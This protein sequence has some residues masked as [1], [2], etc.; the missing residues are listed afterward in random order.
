MGSKTITRRTILAGATAAAGTLTL[1]ACGVLPEQNSVKVVPKAAGTEPN[2]LKSSGG[3]LS[4]DL[5]A[6]HTSINI[7]GHPVNAM[8]YNGTLP[9]PT[10]MA[11]PGDKITVNFTNKL[12]EITNLHTHGFHVSP[13]GNSDNV[14]LEIKDGET[15]TYE[16]QLAADHPSGT[17]WYH[18]HHH[19]KAADQ[20]FAGLYGAIIIEDANPI[21]T[22]ADRVLVIS[23]IAVA[24]DGEIA[25]ATMMDKMMGREGGQVLVNGH[26][27][28][29]F[30]STA[31]GRERLHIVNACTSR[32][33]VLHID[34]ADVQL[35]GMDSGRYGTP[36]DVK[37]ILIAPGNRADVIITL[38]SLAATLRFDSVAHLDS[39]NAPI[40]EQLLA[41]FMPMAAAG[42]TAQSTTTSSPTTTPSLAPLPKMP[43]PRDIRKSTITTKRNFTLAM[44]AMGNMSNMNGGMGSMDG[45]GGMNHTMAGFTINGEAFDMNKINTTVAMGTIEEWTITNTTTMN[46]PFHLHV[47]P[48]QILKIGNQTI[49]DPQ[50]QDVVNVPA[51]STTVVRVAFENHKG[52][53]VY[54]CHILDHEDAGMM[55]LI[56]AS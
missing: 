15:F 56:K 51:K 7:D 4:I 5:V 55:G 16:Y 1:A 30:D 38:R 47:W 6:Q 37:E 50:W 28:P 52:T 11:K 44:P 53:A 13:E 32:Y 9:G 43:T 40:S 42:A 22:T 29:T 27:T 45:M 36:K 33:M 41:T 8:T 18:P 21:E 12:G 3:H 26:I 35:L 2:I 49:A 20:V 48:M 34:H 54:H 10:W 25:Q 14:M 17:Y 19:G 23:D 39:N 31:N 46:H 24:S